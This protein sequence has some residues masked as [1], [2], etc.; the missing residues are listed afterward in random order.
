MYE[1]NHKKG[2][3]AISLEI[4]Y[5]LENVCIHYLYYYFYVVFCCELFFIR[6]TGE[7]LQAGDCGITFN[8]A[9]DEDSGDWICHMGARD[10]HGIEIT[11]KINVKVTGA[12]AANRNNITTNIGDTAHLFCHTS[13][14]N[15]PLEYCRFLSPNFV[16]INLHST[17]MEEK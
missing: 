14:G 12:L 15:R 6:Y 17:V 4:T 10:V 7:S 5:K 9:T 13:N 2:I 3:F 11:D 16:G 1:N 8:R